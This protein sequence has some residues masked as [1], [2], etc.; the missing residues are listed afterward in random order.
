[1]K[2]LKGELSVSMP[3]PNEMPIFFDEPMIRKIATAS[4][5]VI[6]GASGKTSG[7][8]Q[9]SESFMDNIRKDLSIA[10]DRREI[11]EMKRSLDNTSTPPDE[12]KIIEKTFEEKA[13]GLETTLQEISTEAK[14][15]E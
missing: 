2:R 13:R 9:I 8:F 11:R 5:G 10:D 6:S 12:R 1:M 7:D 15:V 4:S 3:K 14:S